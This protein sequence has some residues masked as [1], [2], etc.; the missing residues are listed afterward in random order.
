MNPKTNDQLSKEIKQL[1]EKNADLE[2]FK[3]LYE[4]TPLPYQSLN[5]DGSFKD[6]N[7]AWLNT[8]GYKRNEVIG[9][10]YRDF[11]HPD[12]QAHFEKNFPA[13]KKRG[14]VH[15]V[16]FKIKHK[17]GHYLDISFGGCIGYNPDGSIR[18]TYCVFH[19]ITERKQTEKELRESEEK[20][21][22]QPKY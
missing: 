8:L 20:F 6:V 11:L 3:T 5:E 13:F 18:Q 22:E 15:D 2:K 17:E 12:F 19:D 10:F 4:V 7:P 1:K 14:Y 9:K 21:G 16:Q